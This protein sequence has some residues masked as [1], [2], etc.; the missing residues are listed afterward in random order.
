MKRLTIL[1]LLLASAL[2]LPAQQEGPYL[3]TATENQPLESCTICTGAVWVNTDSVTAV[4]GQ[5]TK[6]TLDP[7]LNC[8]HTAC[9]RSR[10]LTCYNYG[11]NIPQ[12]AV[13]EGVAID[14]IGVPDANGAVRDCTI[15][16]RR[17]NLNNLYGVNMAVNAP[18][19]VNNP[20]H[21]YGASD[22]LWGL[23]W[24]P[25]DVN[26]SDF[27]TYIK[28]QNTSASFH[29]VSIDAVLITVTYSINMEVHSVT[30]SPQSISMNYDAEQSAMNISLLSSAPAH[31]SV[32]DL[33]GRICLVQD[34]AEYSARLDLVTLPTGMYMVVVEQNGTMRAQKFVK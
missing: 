15:A 28:L 27:G 25:D 7:Y 31:I 33:A 21:T 11:F 2:A 8:F 26:S 32:V 19:N 20:L 6:V 4:D 22:E 34:I 9:Y 30:S 17:D 16:L 5:C 13:I 14:V 1:I 10:Y 23:T 18:W 3:P 29:E 24:T 12:N